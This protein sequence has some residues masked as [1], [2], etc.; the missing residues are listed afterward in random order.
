M[1][2]VECLILLLVAWVASGV[3]RGWAVVEA[4]QPSASYRLAFVERLPSLDASVAVAEF[5]AVLRKR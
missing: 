1:D 5:L 3:G 2:R 4:D